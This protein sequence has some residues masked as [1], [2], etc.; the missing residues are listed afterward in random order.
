MKRGLLI[1]AV[2][3]FA[4]VAGTVLAQAPAAEKSPAVAAPAV[5]APPA[6]AT[7]AADAQPVESSLIKEISYDATTKALTVVF[8]ETNEKY[9]Y[10][11]VPE[12]V[13]KQLMAADSK[14]T[15]FVKNIKGKYAFTKE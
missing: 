1:V 2:F 15:Y 7:P 5:A 3:V 9:L 13:Y 14:G 10:K 8:V 12:E 6:P 4:I 11:N